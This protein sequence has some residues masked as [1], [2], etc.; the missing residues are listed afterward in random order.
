M[1]WTSVDSHGQ[2]FVLKELANGRD[3]GALKRLRKSGFG[4]EQ[5]SH[6]PVI[7]QVPGTVCQQ[8]FPNARISPQLE[9]IGSETPPR[10]PLAGLNPA[11]F[12]FARG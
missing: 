7:H 2:K 10:C 3:F 9:N 4:K 6:R 5:T 11:T 12:P 8:E 1:K